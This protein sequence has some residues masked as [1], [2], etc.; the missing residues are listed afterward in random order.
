MS[1][2]A[3]WSKWTHREHGGAY[4]FLTVA[5]GEGE[6][7]GI[8][9]AYYLGTNAHGGMTALVRRLDDWHREMRPLVENSNEDLDELI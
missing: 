5:H 8:E 4:T 9:F 6:D 2:P 3:G 1:H 7:H